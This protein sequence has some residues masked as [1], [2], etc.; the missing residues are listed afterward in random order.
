MELKTT[1][2]KFVKEIEVTDPDTG[3][4]VALAIY[5]TDG[6]GMVGIDSSFLEQDVGP[7]FSPFDRGFLLVLDDEEF[8]E[9]EYDEEY[10]G[11]NYSDVGNHTYIPVSLVDAIGLEHAFK[12]ITGID[13]IHIVSYNEDERYTC[14]DLHEMDIEI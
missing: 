1:K 3:G 11:G 2:A 4:T 6:G 9:V 5:K 8:I 10:T 14:D 13:P 12:E 7:V